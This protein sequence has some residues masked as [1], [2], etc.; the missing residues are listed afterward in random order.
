V[1]AGQFETLMWER[2]GVEP[3]PRRRRRASLDWDGS[4]GCARVYV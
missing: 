1:T 2:R 4:W 3:L